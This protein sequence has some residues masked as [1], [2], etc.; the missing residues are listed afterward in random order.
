M[1]KRSALYIF[2]IGIL[3]FLC[4]AAFSQ[5]TAIYKNPDADFRSALELFQKQKYGSAQKQFSKIISRNEPNT[6]VRIDAEYYSALCALELFNKD[7][8]LLLKNFIADHPE[9]PRTQTVYFYLGKYNYRKKQYTKALEWFAKVD[10][11]DLSN[12]EL[13]ELYFKR[14]YSY[15]ENDSIAA[16]KKDFFEI[17]DIDNKYAAPATYYFGHI[18]YLEKNYQTALQHFTRLKHN[19]NFGPIVPYYI[20]QIFYLQQKYDSAIYFATPLLDSTSKRVLELTKIIGES[21]YRTSRYKESVPYL[22]K[23]KNLSGNLNRSEWYQLGYAYYKTDNSTSAL[24]CFQNATDGKDSLSQ[25]AY[26]HL[27]DCYLKPSPYSGGTSSKMLAKNSFELAYKLDFD[28]AITEDA[29][30][31]YAKLCYELSFSPFNEAITGLNLYIGKYPGSPRIDECYKYLVSVYLST[32]NYKEAMKSIESMKTMNDEMKGAYQKIA[33]MRGLQLYTD[34]QLQEAIVYLNKSLTYPSN[35]NFAGLAS[36]WKGESNYLL[37][38]K[39][40]NAAGLDSAITGFKTFLST[41][42]AINNNE[43]FEA[44]YNLGYANFK[45]ANYTE[46]NTW[47]RK[48][49][50]L[51]SNEPK[52]KLNDAFLRIG[53]GFFMTKDYGN[54]VDYYDQALKTGNRDGDYALYQKSLALGLTGKQEAK[55]KTLSELLA[56]YP[57]KSKY[58]A[59]AKYELANTYLQLNNDENALVYYKKVVAE[60]PECS[61]TSHSLLKI[62]LIESKKKDYNGAIATLDKVLASYPKTNEAFEAISAMK[63]IYRAKSDMDTYEAKIKNIPYAAVSVASLDSS[64]Y[65]VAFDYYDKGDCDNAGKYFIKYISKYLDGIFIVKAMYYKAECDYNAKNYDL[66]LGGYQYVVDKPYGPFTE[67]S[68]LKGSWINF[69]NKNYQNA[70]RLYSRLAAVAEYPANV[71][72]GRV[73]EMRCQWLLGNYDLAVEAAQRVIALD[74]ISN[75]I[76]AEAHLILAKSAMEKQNYDLA[77]SEFMIIPSLTTSEKSAEAKYNLGYIQMLQGQYKESQKTVFELLSQDPGYEYWMG[78]GYILLSD[79][80]VSLKDNFNAK[81]ALKSFIDKSTSTELTA[82]A[83]EKLSRIEEMEKAEAEKKLKKQTDDLNIQFKPD[84]P[85]DS[86]LYKQEGGQ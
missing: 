51:K 33:F 30:F 10:V 78:K 27:A 11:Y 83:K 16:A 70:L 73:G 1:D 46:A 20:A 69:R 49:T 76:K 2:C 21:Y 85:K 9:S 12:E 67:S 72:E 58:E 45:K 53:D 4:I 29:L 48:Y 13:S 42:G 82:V 64:N 68:L 71:N 54:A 66:A 52:E 28:K 5:K 43:F 6:L 17:K 14:G 65:D 63:D 80:Y 39:T 50:G 22:E 34:N 23:Y 47:F 59:A 8:E 24:Y 79:D 41:P 26:Y 35:R 56:T 25:N 44:N 37:S 3:M 86:T 57:G 75:E 74:K 18:S 77:V 81:Y 60:H 36:Y 7:A 38:E 32:K 61:Y 19:D 40:G 62:G 55:T 15:F 31:N 84:N